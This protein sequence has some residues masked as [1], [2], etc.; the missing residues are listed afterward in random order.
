MK[1]KTV[2]LASLALLCTLYAQAPT[3]FEVASVKKSNESIRNDPRR[4]SGRVS[5]GPGTTSPGQF[6]VSGM[7]LN[8]LLSRYAFN[9]M[10]YQYSAPPWMEKEIYDVSAKVPPGITADQFRTMLQSLLIDRFKI[11]LHH[12]QRELMSYDLVV[13]K[14]GLRMK[15]SKFD[16]STPPLVPDEPLRLEFDADGFPVIPSNYGRA[17]GFGTNVKGEF[18]FVTN[19]GSIKQL[20]ELLSRNL[21]LPIEDQTGLKGY[22]AY[23]L[24]FGHGAPVAGAA[25]SAGSSGD[26]GTAAGLDLDVAPT[27]FNALPKQL[28]LRLEPHKR[29]I[30]V[31]VIDK[32]EKTPV[33][34]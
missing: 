25:G 27:A 23:L 3:K 10:A 22:Y 18:A 31:L 15:P 24:H 13:A 6:T 7:S 26:A 8:D 21:N 12:E 29:P 4:G 33:E 14:G 2:L 16:D 28:G 34:N 30:D 11:E 32:A 9:L 19:K 5:G 17:T 1:T 20:I